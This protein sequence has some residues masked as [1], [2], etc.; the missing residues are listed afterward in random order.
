MYSLNCTWSK[1]LELEE[2]LLKIRKN[3]SFEFDLVYLFVMSKK[4]TFILLNLV[5]TIFDK[6]ISYSKFKQQQ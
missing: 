4:H 1:S 3:Q 2:V 6:S 5:E